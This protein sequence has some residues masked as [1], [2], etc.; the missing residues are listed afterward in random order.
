[1]RVVSPPL[2]LPYTSHRTDI[3]KAEMPPQKKA[4]FTTPASGFEV[5]ES[6]AAGAARQP[7]PTLEA[8]L[9]RDRV[10]EMGYGIT[11]TWDEIVEAMLEIAPTTLEGVNQRVTEL[12]TTVRQDTNEFYVRFEDA[13]DDRDFLRARVNTLF[14]DRSA[15]IEAYTLEAR[16][17]EPQD[18]PAEAGSSFV[19]FTKM[20]PK[21]RTTRTSTP[22][23]RMTDAQIKALIDQGVADALVQF[24][25]CTLQGN[26]LTWW[27]SHVR[28]VGHDVAY[29]IPWKTLKKMTTDK[30]CPRS[31]IKK[32]ETK[33]WNLKVKGTDVLSYNQCFQELA[34]MCDMMFSEESDEVEK[35]VGGLPDMI[36]GSMK[37][38]KPKT[39]QEAIEFAT[40][41]MDKKIPTLAERQAENKRKFEDSS[42][43][44][45]NQ[46]PF[47]RNNC[48]PKC[49]NCKRI[50]HLAQNCKSQHAAANNN[51]RAQ[52]ANQRVLTCF[53][54]GAQGHFRSNCPKLKKRNQGNQA[55]N[56]NAVARAYAVGTARTNLNSN[57][58]TDHGYDVELANSR[59]IWVILIRGCTLNFLN[60]PFNIDLMPVE[61]GSFDVIIGM[62]WL[63]MYHAM[64]VCAEKIVRIPWGNETLIV[65][66]DGSDNRHGSR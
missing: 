46:Q 52:A 12:A 66:G 63:S 47:K 65:C 59:I 62:D 51:Q 48:A 15:A 17:L 41:L 38:S 13:Q 1:M 5:G 29:A 56:G 19:Y 26:A 58:V 57:V 23:T 4:C 9:W 27:N 50:G 24:A 21:R 25:T 34:L 16:D 35:Y 10:R 7:G 39:M 2:L 36:H 3:P 43:N 11:D 61:L 31:E 28:A 32:L 14:R 44:N 53:E 18:E 49:T 33:M 42:R 8:D 20:P 37:A 6:S 30:Y 40:E 64:I 60:H 55:G 45:Q 22:T 54:C